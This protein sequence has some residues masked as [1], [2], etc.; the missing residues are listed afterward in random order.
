MNLE[1]SFFINF[2]KFQ[3]NPLDSNRLIVDTKE[4]VEVYD[5]LCSCEVPIKLEAMEVHN[6]TPDLLEN[7][8][9]SNNYLLKSKSKRIK[10]NTKK[11]T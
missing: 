2:S 7:K 8:T 3:Y 11:S 10:K 6:I 1:L 9:K 5:E 4:P